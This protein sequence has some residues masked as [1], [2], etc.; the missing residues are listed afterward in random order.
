VLGICNGFQVLVKAGLL[1][2]VDGDADNI[3]ATLNLNDSARFEDR[4]VYLKRSKVKCAW[5]ERVRD[6]IYLPVAHAEGKFIPANKKVL[7]ALK[8]NGQIVL[9][10][11]DSSGEKTAYPGNPNGSTDEIAGICDPTGRILGMMPHPERFV[12][13]TQHPRWTREKL[14]DEGDGLAIFR[15]GVEYVRRNFRRKTQTVVV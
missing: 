6:I 14:K 9:R 8:K 13:R 1:P 10:Y 11:S 7:D 12:E 2:N 3:D 15:S 5:T 4:W